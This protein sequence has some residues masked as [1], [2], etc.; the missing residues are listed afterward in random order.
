[1]VPCEKW[2][3][4]EKYEKEVLDTVGTDRNFFKRFRSTNTNQVRLDPEDPKCKQYPFGHRMVPDDQPPAKKAR[5]LLIL[6]GRLKSHSDVER[7]EHREVKKRYRLLEEE[8]ERQKAHR[9]DE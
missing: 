4:G 7:A 1:M 8:F 2:V 6:T 3:R 9:V 5:Q